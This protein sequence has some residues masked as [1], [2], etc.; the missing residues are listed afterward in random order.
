[1]RPAFGENR[2]SRVTSRNSKLP[3]MK[4]GFS[5]PTSSTGT[6]TSRSRKVKVSS[7]MAGEVFM[8]LSRKAGRWAA[9]IVALDGKAGPFFHLV[10][11]HP[12]CPEDRQEQAPVAHHPGET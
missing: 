5:A 12:R 7:R 8:P 10:G 6:S 1:M 2:P 4:S 11:R 9:R 3:E